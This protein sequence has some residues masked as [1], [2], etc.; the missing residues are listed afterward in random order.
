[1]YF[2]LFVLTMLLYCDLPGSPCLSKTGQVLSLYFSFF[3]HCS[4]TAM[5]IS[6]E[7]LWIFICFFM[8]ISTGLFAYVLFV[9]FDH[10]IILWVV[11]PMLIQHRYSSSQSV[12]FIFYSLLHGI[13]LGFNSFYYDHFH[14]IIYLCFICSFWPTPIL[15]SFIHVIINSK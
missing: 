15:T 2:Y 10:V 12:F 8:T 14:L 5:A 3:I 9:H 6:M 4:M 13:I 7:V 11:R 1:M